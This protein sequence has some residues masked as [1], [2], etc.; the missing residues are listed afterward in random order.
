MEFWP[1]CMATN[2][3]SL[4]YVP[5]GLESFFF[6]ITCFW[7]MYT[8]VTELVKW[9]EYTGKFILWNGVRHA[10]DSIIL[11]RIKKKKKK[12]SFFLFE[13]IIP[14]HCNKQHWQWL[15]HLFYLALIPCESCY[16]IMCDD[17]LMSESMKEHIHKDLC[18][19][20]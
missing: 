3:E 20:A 8:Q 17:W 19:S 12:E 18:S 13:L 16:V 11:I 2:T 6:L 15:I 1:P 10:S 4:Y 9:N 14:V 5:L 7:T